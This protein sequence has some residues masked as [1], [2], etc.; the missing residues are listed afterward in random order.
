MLSGGP[1]PFPERSN[2][3]IR[4]Y[5]G[6]EHHFLRICFMDENNLQYRFA[7]DVDGPAFVRLRVGDILKGGIRIAGRDFQWLAYSMSSLKEHAV[8]FLEPF[9]FG[10]RFIDSA[11]IWRSLGDFSKAIEYPAL[12]GAR[13]SQAFTATDPGVVIEAEES[14]PIKD[15][16]RNGNVFTDGEKLLITHLCV[17]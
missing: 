4:M 9:T 8:W 11:I 13:I 15:I 6:K 2:R 14:I 3:V 17:C 5:P 7:R 16:E 1:G 10:G 12:Y